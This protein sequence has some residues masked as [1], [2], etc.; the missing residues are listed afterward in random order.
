[1]KI[2]GARKDAGYDDGNHARACV[3]QT[4]GVSSELSVSHDDR[5]E[6]NSGFSLPFILAD[7]YVNDEKGRC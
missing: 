7:N 1:M 3:A 4:A 5:D 2:S 6:E